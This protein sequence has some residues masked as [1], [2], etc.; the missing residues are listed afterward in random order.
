V[1]ASLKT[2][3]EAG[4]FEIWNLMRGD[5]LPTVT[6]RRVIDSDLFHRQ[7]GRIPAGEAVEFS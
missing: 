6:L 2:I 3:S 5:T 7:P 4:A 1:V